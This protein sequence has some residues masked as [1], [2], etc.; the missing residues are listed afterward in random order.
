MNLG[1]WSQHMRGPTPDD[2]S[3]GVICGFPFYDRSDVRPALPERV[4]RFLAEGAA[5]VVFSLGTAAVHVPGDF[6]HVAAEACRLTGRRGILLA[7]PGA[8]SGDG[9]VPR[10]LPASVLAVD[11]VPCSL[12]LP[13]GCCTVH[14]GG[15]GSTGQALRS[16]RP[17]VVVPH[18]HDQFHN[19]LHARRLGVA[20]MLPRRR[21]TAKRLA[22]AIE[23]VVRPEVGVRAAVLREALLVEDGAGAACAEV[24]RVAAAPAGLE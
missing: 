10:E 6:Y 22:E 3:N 18:A 23:R 20:E 17:A 2:P 15:I 1:L 16:G 19:G 14:H 5:P 12:L 7:G 24:E 4:E 13:R 8:S 9:A 21:M 11:Y